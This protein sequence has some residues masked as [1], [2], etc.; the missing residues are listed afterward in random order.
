M[1]LMMFLFT[2]ASVVRKDNCRL[3]F[4]TGIELSDIAP[5]P[6]GDDIVNFLEP[7]RFDRKL[8][9]GDTIDERR[10]TKEPT[11]ITIVLLILPG[12]LC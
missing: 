3:Q 5:P 11:S 4:D 9:S 6:D 12:V 2:T 10:W 8:A 1:E 7:F